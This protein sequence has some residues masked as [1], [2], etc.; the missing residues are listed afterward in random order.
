[1]ALADITLA[2]G[3]ASPVSHVFTYVGTQ[4]GRVVRVDMSAD[5]EQPLSLTH[6]HMSKKVGGKTVQSHLLRVDSTVLDADGV[7]PHIANIRL[8]CD[9]PNPIL[10]DAL[11]DNLAAFIRNWATSANV[12]A[13]LRGSVG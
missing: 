2:D 11:A 1:M 8:M 5:A 6:G 13:W 3:A 9:V 4:N 12:R 7:T 10:S